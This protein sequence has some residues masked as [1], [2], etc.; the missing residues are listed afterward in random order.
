MSGEGLTNKVRLAFTE[1]TLFGFTPSSTDLFS[2]SAQLDRQLMAKLFPHSHWRTRFETQSPR[3]HPKTP[4]WKK[5][6]ATSIRNWKC[7][8]PSPNPL[9][10]NVVK[11]F[12]CKLIATL[13]ILAIGV[14]FMFFEF[15]RAVR[16]VVRDVSTEL[17]RLWQ[18]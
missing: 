4:F 7:Q 12:V 6:L 11:V 3:S 13:V 1:E 16:R 17:V 5:P 9:L 2:L 18:M 14:A 15:Y 8:E 10:E